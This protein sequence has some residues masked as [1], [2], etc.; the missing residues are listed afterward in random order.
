[1]RNLDVDLMAP[2]PAAGIRRDKGAQRLGVTSAPDV[3]DNKKLVEMLITVEK[4][5]SRHREFGFL[6]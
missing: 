1:M 4:S 5:A 3:Q 6:L 2:E